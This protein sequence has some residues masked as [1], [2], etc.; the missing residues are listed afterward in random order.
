M[1]GQSPYTIFLG[2]QITQY[3]TALYSYKLHSDWNSLSGVIVPRIQYSLPGTLDTVFFYRL[4]AWNPDYAHT[5]LHALFRYLVNVI[6]VR[7]LIITSKGCPRLHFLS[8]DLDHSIPSRLPDIVTSLQLC[9]LCCQS[10]RPT[11][12]TYS[13][14]HLTPRWTRKLKYC[15]RSCNCCA[16]TA[17][18]ATPAQERSRW[19]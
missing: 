14:D 12:E 9:S 3:L 13:R 19:A 4:T 7:K 8:P 2:P 18:Q 5:T 15:R 1:S 17:D 10:K 16:S 11:P 6:E